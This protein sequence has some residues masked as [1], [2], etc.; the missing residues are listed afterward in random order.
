MVT[1]G[2][3]APE[4]ARDVEAWAACVAGALDTADY[5]AGLAAAGFVEVQVTAKDAASA[6]LAL[7]AGRP[8]AALITA[9]K[10]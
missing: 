4:V 5:R 7:P 10:P 8:F 1:A 2:P 3:L 6:D 9:R